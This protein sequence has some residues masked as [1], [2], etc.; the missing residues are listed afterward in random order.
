MQ[1]ST[2][3]TGT[4]Q[5]GLV[6][7]IARRSFIALIAIAAGLCSGCATGV[8]GLPT[9][10]TGHSAVVQGAVYTSIGGS[11]EWWVEYGPTTAYGSETSH[12][13]DNLAAGETE[14]ELG[15]ITGL[16]LASTYHYRFCARD[17]QQGST[18]G[19]G[20]DRTFTT[21]SVEC[22]ATVTQDLK[23]TAPMNCSNPSPSDG[24]TIGADGVDINLAGYSLTG[25]PTTVG[26]RNSGHDDVTIRNGSMAGWATA[27]IVGGANRNS[28]RGI[29]GGTFSVGGGEGNEIR[30]SSGRFFI[31]SDGFV[32]ADSDASAG[33]GS[34]SSPAIAVD[35]D[36]G[37][38]VRNEIQGGPFE[39][40]IVVNGS[41]NRILESEFYGSTEGCIAIEA[42]DAN[43]VR[44]NVV[45]NCPSD[46]A[47]TTGIQIGDGIFVAAAAS[48]TLLR[49]NTVY[50][51]G[52]DG[53]DTRS[54]S[55]SLMHNQANENADFGIDAAPGVI[56][57]GGNGAA[58]NGNPLQCRNVF[59]S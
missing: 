44:D 15:G 34:R 47:G 32:L 53:I 40:G 55:T 33:F 12:I 36:N 9:D 18:P 3:L 39:P 6:L 26:I 56:D 22:G 7:L 2:R 21:Q 28:I 59:C 38:F 48:G 31:G 27:I 10:A 4:V 25:F 49:D 11:V 45:H 58:L 24:F 37:R 14:T 51:N 19:C 41:G 43:I 1:R 17:S 8:T 52:D 13:F 30:H 57:L 54:G 23:L 16:E 20:V 50:R 42:G 29:D 5:D 35:S 46:S